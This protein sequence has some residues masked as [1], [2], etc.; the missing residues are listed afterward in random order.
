MSQAQGVTITFWGVRG[1][2][3]C[4]GPEHCRYGGNTAC[5]EVRCGPHLLVF[6]AG[7]GI[8]PLGNSLAKEKPGTIDLFLGHTHFDHVVGLPFFTPLFDPDA[9]VRI[10]AGH[11]KP[12]GSTL[13]GALC[14]FMDAPLFPVPPA[15]FT[16]EVAFRDF[17]AGE[18]LTPQPGIAMRTAPLNH[19][20]GAT[21]Y[22]VD[23]EGQSVCYVS[24][25]EHEPGRPDR[26]VLD[27]VD[28][29]DVMIYDAAY[30]DAELPRYRGWGHSTWEEGVRLADA[31]NVDRLVL[32]HHDPTHDDDT[33]DRIA[34]AAAERRPGTI[35]AHEGLVLTL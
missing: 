9:R 4:P 33:M 22:R 30:T 21:A 27:L 32:F 3:A 17:H 28:G 25:T 20:N 11:L 24:D 13:Y 2:I 29:T 10:W 1:S 8:R 34:T 31:A 26:T 23:Y 14:Q 12:D 7:T 35:T 5:V 19:P 6:D 18:E 16:A 15:V